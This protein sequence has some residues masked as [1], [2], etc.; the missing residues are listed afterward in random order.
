MDPLGRLALAAITFFALHA[1]V[2]GTR[3]REALVRAIGEGPFRGLFSLASL[4]SLVWLSIAYRSSPCAP[5]WVL[6]RAFSWLPLFVM[7]F[8]LFL[9]AGAFSVPNPT[10]VGGERVLSS[11]DAARGALRITRHPFLWGVM[12]WSAVHAVVLG[13]TAG[14]W[15]FGSF[16]VTAA[17]GTRSIDRKRAR[18]GGEAW[19]RYRAVTSN[20]PLGAVVSGRNRLRA[21]ELWLP[22]LFGVALLLA[23]LATHR[24]LFGVSPWPI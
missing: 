14:L 24:W 9:V 12:L 3:L 16:L 17:L 2:S 21:K 20:W 7:P 6:P 1:V 22:A 10:A 19:R 11:G 23:L 4:G 8:A 18:S 15:F 5:L 13:S